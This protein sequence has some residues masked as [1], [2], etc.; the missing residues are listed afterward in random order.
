M[1]LSLLK[2]AVKDSDRDTVEKI[3][4]SL[5]EDVLEAALEADIQVESIEEA[6]QGEYKNDE[7]FAYE[8]A[9]QLGEIDLRNQPWPLSCIDWAFAAKELMY[10]YVESN[11]YYFRNL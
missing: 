4:D 9:T 8:M 5:G 11:G 10:D 6:Y 2:Q 1:K 7:D 3:I